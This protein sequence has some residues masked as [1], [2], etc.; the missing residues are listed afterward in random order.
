MV[1]QSISKLAGRSNH[2]Q[3]KK[4]IQKHAQQKILKAC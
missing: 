2:T 1:L 4:E 3:P